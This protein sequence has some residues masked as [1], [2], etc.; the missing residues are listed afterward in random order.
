MTK[1]SSSVGPSSVVMDAVEW[2]GASSDVEVEGTAEGDGFGAIVAVDCWSSGLCRRRRARSG[3]FQVAVNLTLISIS[4][5]TRASYH[6]YRH[7]TLDLRQLL[8]ALRLTESHR[9]LRRRH[10]SHDF[11]CC[12]FVACWSIGDLSLQNAHGTLC[13]MSVPLPRPRCLCLT[14]VYRTC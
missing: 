4:T 5:N 12:L 8:H 6:R 13:Y 9:T 11:I 14:R 7:S 3:V 10:V 2:A 1:L